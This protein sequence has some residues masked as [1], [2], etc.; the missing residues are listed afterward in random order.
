MNRFK[1]STRVAAL[2]YLMSVLLLCIGG[3]GLWGLVQTNQALRSLY[4]DNLVTTSEIHQIEALLLRNRLALAVAQVTPDAATIQSST[5]EVENNIS[6]ITQLWDSY[7]CAPPRC[8]ESALAQ[9]FTQDRKRFVQE[10]LL[11]TVAALKANDIPCRRT[12]AVVEKSA[13]VC[14]GG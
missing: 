1:I 2:A 12:I 5:T 9:R 4:Q 14:P 8:T 11:V 10:G 3:L 6:A 13:P 7:L